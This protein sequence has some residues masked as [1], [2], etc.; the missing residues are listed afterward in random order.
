MFNF[1]I[2]IQRPKRQKEEDMPG[3][4]ISRKFLLLFEN[5]FN[6]RCIK[7]TLKD[8][9]FSGCRLVKRKFD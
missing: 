4:L 5:V 8:G 9:V 3:V 1:L 7:D 6:S 2:L